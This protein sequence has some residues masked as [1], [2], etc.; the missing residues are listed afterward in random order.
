MQKGKI[1]VIDDEINILKMIEL[2][3]SARGFQVEIFSNPLDA[4]KRFRET[5][6][7]IAFIDLK[8][9]PINGIEVL[10][11]LKKISAETTAIMMTAYSSIETAVEAIKKG[12]YDYIAKRLIIKNSILCDRVLR[13]PLYE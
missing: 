10:T 8:M 5:Y 4:I 13:L 2:S 7:D 6:F 9:Q 11:E 12:A 1:A 3:L